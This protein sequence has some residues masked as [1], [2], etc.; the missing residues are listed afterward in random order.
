MMK[1]LT[2]LLLALMLV[3]VLAACGCEHEFGAADCV[4]PATCTL[5]GETEGTPLGHVWMAATC[6]APKTCEVC[7]TAEGEAKG[8]AMVEAT[9]E[10]AKHC[11]NCNL[12]EGEALGH[13]W[14][15]ATTED[16]KTCEV[17]ALTEGERII[18]DFR[19]TTDATRDIQGKW[20][21]EISL[22]GEMM[23][24]PS[25]E[26]ELPVDFILDFGND[27]TFSVAIQVTDR[28][29]EVITQYTVDELY[30]EY[31]REGMDKETVDAQ[32]QEE[33]GM[34]LHELVAQDMNKDTFNEVYGRL[35]E[36][37]GFGG[38]YYVNNGMLYTGANWEVMMEV[39]AYTQEE[40]TL[41]I[42]GLLV[43]L[44]PDAESVGRRLVTE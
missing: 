8:H 32:I 1:K 19:F 25:F 22:T 34:T 4:N 15:D 38:V 39:N 17:C 29:V 14:L 27:G 42:K 31:A 7:G 43:S 23:G 21:F 10:E 36:A 26:G 13:V 18:T 44:G 5:C 3:V 28:F 6:D 9:C 35:F 41:I 12:T 40:D 30:A 33:Y 20:V 16:P 2:M 11:E 24:D 37:I